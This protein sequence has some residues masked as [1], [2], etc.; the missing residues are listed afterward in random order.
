MWDNTLGL[1]QIYIKYWQTSGLLFKKTIGNHVCSWTYGGFFYKYKPNKCWELLKTVTGWTGYSFY[2]IFLALL[3]LIKKVMTLFVSLSETDWERDGFYE[4]YLL[5]D[6]KGSI[7]LSL[8]KQTHKTSQLG[9][10]GILSDRSKRF[11]F[12]FLRR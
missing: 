5:F 12:R 11:R 6:C 10:Y 8:A 1:V 4:L 2:H 3:K 7:S 9:G